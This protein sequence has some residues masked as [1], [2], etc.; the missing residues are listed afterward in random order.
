MPMT[1]REYR[2]HL[3]ARRTHPHKLSGG[4]TR[5]E[6][7]SSLYLTLVPFVVGEYF[8]ELR[9]ATLPSGIVFPLAFVLFWAFYYTYYRPGVLESQLSGPSKWDLHSIPT[10]LLGTLIW[11]AKVFVVEF[12]DFLLSSFLKRK[13]HVSHPSRKEPLR[14]VETQQRPAQAPQGPPPVPREVE[15][16]LAVLGLKDCRDWRTIQKRYR[17]LAKQFHP[18]LNPDITTAGN[19]FMIYDGAYRRLVTVRE[20][21]FTIQ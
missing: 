8:A 4:A 21:Y 2:D 6:S 15:N 13:E 20:K 5:A 9:F 17:E 10:V 18:D 14:R 16:A 19:R 12:T 1:A 3:Y 11:F 7:F